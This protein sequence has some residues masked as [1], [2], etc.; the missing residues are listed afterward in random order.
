[1]GVAGELR[2]GGMTGARAKVEQE[3]DGGGRERWFLYC[4]YNFI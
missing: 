3:V 4:G 2:G 1:M